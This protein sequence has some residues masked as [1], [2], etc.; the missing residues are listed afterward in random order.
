MSS[1]QKNLNG[2]YCGQEGEV[3]GAERTRGFCV[4]FVGMLGVDEYLGILRGWQTGDGCALCVLCL[5]STLSVFKNNNRFL[6]CCLFF[7]LCISLRSFLQLASSP[8][9]RPI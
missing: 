6:F 2:K 4:L 8:D 7:F 3:G 5:P 9:G 1:S